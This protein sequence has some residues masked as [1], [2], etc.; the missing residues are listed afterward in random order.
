MKSLNDFLLQQNKITCLG[1]CRSVV[2]IIKAN[3]IVIYNVGIV[4][5]KLQ[6][7]V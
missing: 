5:F 4:I 6:I 1:R 2:Y 7:M 3:V